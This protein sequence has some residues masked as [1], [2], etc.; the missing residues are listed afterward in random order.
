MTHIKM[1]CLSLI[2]IPFILSGCATTPPRHVNNICSVFKQHPDWYQDAKAAEKRWHLPIHIQMAIIHQESK[3]DAYAKPE[4]TKLLWVIPWTRPSSAYGYA[5]ALDMTWSRYKRARGR[6]L[7]SRSNFEDSVDF[8]G[9]Y[10]NQAHHRA[11]ISLQ[12]PFALYLAYHE[13]VGGYQRKT[14]RRKRWLI[15]V[16]RKVRTRA[17]IYEAQLGRCESKFKHASWMS[18]L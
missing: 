16:A 12:D 9:W 11:G 13:G 18:W 10:A 3:F 8:V 14:Y 6:M 15:N 1:A 17:Q 4:R 2:I 7:A 5:Q